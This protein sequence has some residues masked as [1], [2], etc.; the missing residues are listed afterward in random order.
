M[1]VPLAPAAAGAAVARRP[2]LAW[3]AAAGV[4]ANLVVLVPGLTG[5]QPLREAACRRFAYVR[6]LPARY[7]GA[8]FGDRP[9]DANPS[10]QRTAGAAACGR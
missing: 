2:A 9:L 1:L 5:P 3:L 4:A 8:V 6:V 10:W 7:P